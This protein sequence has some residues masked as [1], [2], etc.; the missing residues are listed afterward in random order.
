MSTSTGM[1]PTTVGLYRYSFTADLALSTNTEGP[2]KYSTDSTVPSLAMTTRKRTVPV[3]F[4]ASAAG[5][6]TE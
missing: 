6:Y 1:L 3:M 2:D 4:A 5:G